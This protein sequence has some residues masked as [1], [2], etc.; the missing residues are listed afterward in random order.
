[1]PG[2]A[3]AAHGLGLAGSRSGGGGEGPNCPQGGE[4]LRRHHQA[5]EGIGDC[6]KGARCS[7][8]I[9]ADPQGGGPGRH[10]QGDPAAID[11]FIP[12]PLPQKVIATIRRAHSSTEAM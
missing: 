6:R 5:L 4:G 9:G 8:A 10:S 12:G 2:P 7:A 11:G 1:M 3:E